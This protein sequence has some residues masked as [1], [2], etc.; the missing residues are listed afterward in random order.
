[1]AGPTTPHAMRIQDGPAPPRKARV[2]LPSGTRPVQLVPVKGFAPIP[3]GDE[4]ETTTSLEIGTYA[5]YAPDDDDDA[6]STMTNEV[7]SSSGLHPI[8]DIPIEVVEVEFSADRVV[9]E[10]GPT[11]LAEA[12]DT[13]RR[14]TFESAVRALKERQP[15]DDEPPTVTAPNAVHT[16][17]V[18]EDDPQTITATPAT[19]PHPPRAQVNLAEVYGALETVPLAPAVVKF[20]IESVEARAAARAAGLPLPP[21]IPP[22]AAVYMPSPLPPVNVQPEPEPP[23][24][25]LAVE[26][27]IGVITFLA[28]AAPAFWYFFIR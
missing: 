25:S 6:R 1:M 15:A 20:A 10:D 22:P 3:A 26:L 11:L 23:P 16:M 12:V 7:T 4:A 21:P 18:S 2:H 27:T 24:R 17:R 9:R 8:P 28:V 5:T 19:Q 13:E 14:P